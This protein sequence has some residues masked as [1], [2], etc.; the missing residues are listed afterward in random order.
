MLMT[1]VVLQTA[2]GVLLPGDSYV[3]IAIRL[4]STLPVALAVFRWTFPADERRIARERI[5]VLA[6][7]IESLAAR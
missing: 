4:F 6:S 1:A 7:G 3:R 2:L 5:R